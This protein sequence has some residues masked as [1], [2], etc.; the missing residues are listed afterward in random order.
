[1]KYLCKSIEK[2]LGTFLPGKHAHEKVSLLITANSNAK[3]L[4]GAGLK[5][6]NELKWQHI[7]FVVK[8]WKLFKASHRK[9]QWN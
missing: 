9:L 8:E 3:L 6:L 7:H 5:I 2:L 4:K 1:M